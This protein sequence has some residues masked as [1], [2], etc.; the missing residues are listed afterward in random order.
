MTIYYE[1]VFGKQRRIRS[2][3]FAIQNRRDLFRY[4][5]RDD[6]RFE[7]VFEKYGD[8][9]RFAAKQTAYNIY[10]SLL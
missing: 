4:H 9:F 3:S 6:I 1:R 10:F 8:Q 5:E 2:L 7:D